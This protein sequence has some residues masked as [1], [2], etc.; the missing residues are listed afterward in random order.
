MYSS[1]IASPLRESASASGSRLVTSS[2]S[3]IRKSPRCPPESAGLRTTGQDPV[4]RLGDAGQ[5]ESSAHDALVGHRTRDLVSDSRQAEP[6]GNLCCRNDCA[7]AGDREH[8]HDAVSCTDL[9]DAVDVAEVDL[10]GRVDEGESGGLRIRVDRDHPEP[11]LARVPDGGN[12]RDAR[13][14]EEQGSVF[15]PLTGPPGG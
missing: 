11:G 8:S 12:L 3:P 14:E 2:I 5:L 7:V 1:R 6:G 13:A 15:A 9:D 4:R 10:L